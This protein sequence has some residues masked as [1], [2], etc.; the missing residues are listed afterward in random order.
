V[1]SDLPPAK[2][3]GKSWIYLHLLELPDPAKMWHQYAITSA[4]S[5]TNAP[6][7]DA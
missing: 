4:N 5:K 3:K 7:S 2:E 6:A 1:P